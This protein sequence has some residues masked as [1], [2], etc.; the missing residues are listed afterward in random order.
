[1]GAHWISIVA[2]FSARSSDT[3]GFRNR[4]AAIL[5]VTV[6]LTVVP[7]ASFRAVWWLVWT[8]FFAMIALIVLWR[9]GHRSS[10]ETARYLRYR[11]G[12]LAML[13]VPAYALVQ[14]AGIAP[15]LPQEWLA[16]PGGITDAQS[17]TISVLP[18][19]SLVGAFRSVGYLILFALMIE[20]ASRYRRV[21]M[22]ARI[23]FVG[24]VLQAFW[25]L[26]ALHLLDDFALWGKADYLGYATGTFVNRNSLAT[27]LGFGLVLGIGLIAHQHQKPKIR[28]TRKVTGILGLGVEGA[29]VLAGQFIIL[30]ALLDTGSRGGV[31]VS[32][33]GVAVTLT[34]VRAMAGVSLKQ[35]LLE[36]G[37]V[38]VIVILMIAVL[39]GGG[40]G[41]LQSRFLFSLLDGGTR[42]SIY[43]QSLELVALRPWTGF[44][45]DAFGPAFEA[46]RA[47]PLDRN[48]FYDLA[49]NTYLGFWAEQGL[50]IGSIPF[51]VIGLCLFPLLAARSVETRFPAMAAAAVGVMV[52]A[53]VHSLIDF[54][55]EM[56]TNAYF[57]TALL[58]LGLAD[59]KEQGSAHV[60]PSPEVSSSAAETSPD[61]MVELTFAR[62]GPAS[63][64]EREES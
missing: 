51:I 44:G 19:A 23:L 16:Q 43:S 40:T 38:L 37:A 11:W 32:A 42:L 24:V 62:R 30:A 14:S 1:M 47:P 3:S 22:V 8:A 56:P 18:S 60:A 29:L 35:R 13:L 6:I 45:F 36:G 57:F 5:A 4:V 7:V 41:S 49:H 20:V 50:I 28:E 54:S 31:M 64:A 53:A 21:T 10:L 26:V 52:I 59:R 48:V 33:L 55:L 2:D 39:A 34:L 58:A 15:W 61:T 17:G 46:V 63:D 27:Y 9:K 25:A 12:L